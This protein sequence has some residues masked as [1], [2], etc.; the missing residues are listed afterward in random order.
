MEATVQYNDY[1]GTT[2]ADRSDVFVE[3]PGQMSQI[4]FDW[5]NIPLDG[6]DYNFVGISVYSTNVDD[7]H[8]T[9]YFKKRDTQQVVKV[10]RSSVKLQTV[11]D[12]FKRFEF[13][14]GY[15]LEDID[16]YQV[17]EVAKEE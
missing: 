14:V 6:K 10:I 4:I 16:E 1:L 7:A 11:L 3:L 2:A 5:F 9:F 13:Q 8:A 17:E 12:M 15:H